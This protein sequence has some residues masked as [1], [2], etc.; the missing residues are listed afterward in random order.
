M[1]DPE[2]VNRG[3]TIT[4]NLPGASPYRVES[5]SDQKKLNNLSLAS[6]KLA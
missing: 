5:P 6:K 4:T 3:A 1:E 2:T